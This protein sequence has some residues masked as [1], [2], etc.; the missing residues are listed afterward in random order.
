MGSFSPLQIVLLIVA[1][2]AAIGVIV[3]IVRNRSTFSGYEE[4]QDDVREIAAAIRGEVFRD[5]EDVVINGDYQKRPLVIRFSNAEN[6]P[7][8]NLRMQAPTT[9]TLTVFPTGERM[10]EAARVAVRTADE[11]FD[12]R[13]QTRS[14]QPTQAK[15]FLDRSTTAHL[16]RVM[17]SKNTFFSLGSSVMELSELLIPSAPGP[18]VL[19]H[20]RQLLRLD[21][22]LKAMPGADTVKV[23]PLERERH[24]AGRAAIAIG[25]AVALMSVFAAT[26]VPP[27]TS[28][29]EAPAAPAG[30][31]PVDAVS[32]PEINGY[33]AA[34]ESDFD[35]AALA[36]M[37]GNHLEAQG[38]LAGDFS[39]AGHGRDAAY[40][41]IG[42]KGEHRLVLL[43]ENANRYD[44][45]FQSLAA[46]A[47]IPKDEVGK[48]EWVRG[49]KPG[50]IDGD[51]LLVIRNGTDPASAMV[52]FLSGSQVTSYAPVNYQNI[53]L[54]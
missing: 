8:L 41:L 25:A 5:G 49:Q 13:F 7:G 19:E 21:E 11:Q 31:L 17:C 52:L 14:D 39:G 22:A 23:A 27:R 40:F 44:A 45:I 2:V 34:V 26:R 30:V 24:L 16:Q 53:I 48:I 54:P 43:T 32:I 1:A 46:V 15:M 12:A 10:G 6:T 51:G 29:A 4:I 47:V 18:H 28:M 35:T 3:S 9:F 33:R 42:P 36:W 37:Q 50:A 20:L 38:R